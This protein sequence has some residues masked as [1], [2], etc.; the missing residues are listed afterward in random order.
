MFV[1]FLIVSSNF[2]EHLFLNLRSRAHVCRMKIPDTGRQLFSLIFHRQ[3]AKTARDIPENG[4]TRAF[5][6]L[7]AFFQV[8]FLAM[9]RVSLRLF[10]HFPKSL[11]YSLGAGNFEGLQDL[12]G[13][14]VGCL[15]TNRYFYSKQCIYSYYD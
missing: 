1:N 14:F 2:N 10:R 15:G 11:N 8:S 9:Q 3:P 4:P 6:F 13:A 5:M 12:L 7:W